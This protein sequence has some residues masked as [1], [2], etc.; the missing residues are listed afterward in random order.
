[1]NDP[2]VH[3]PTAAEKL[4][5]AISE[6]IRETKDDDTML[7]DWFLAFGVM[8]SNPDSCGDPGCAILY[9]HDYATSDISPWGAL[10]VADLCASD[11]RDSLNCVAREED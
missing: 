7:M 10:G 3:V 9:N 8:K 11:L 4:Q 6:F 5:A 1:M 2:E